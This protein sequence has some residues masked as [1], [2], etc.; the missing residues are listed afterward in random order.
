MA[1]YVPFIVEY[2]YL[3]LKKVFN[4][5]SVNYSESIH[6]IRIPKKVDKFEDQS[7]VKTVEIFQSLIT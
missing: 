7:L 3:N 4:Q 2:F 5:S 1:P 6:F